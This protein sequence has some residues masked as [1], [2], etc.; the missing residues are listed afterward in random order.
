MRRHLERDIAELGR[1]VAKHDQLGP[2]GHLGIRT[3]HLAPDLVDQRLRALGD[4]SATSIGRFHPRASARAMLPAPISPICI[5]ARLSGL[6]PAI[7]PQDWLK[8][9]F[10]ISLARSSAEISTLRG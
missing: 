9:P 10:S 2:L 5:R 3:E 6:R 1:L 4:G 7:A 8:K